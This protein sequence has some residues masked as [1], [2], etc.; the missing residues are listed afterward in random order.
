MIEEKAIKAKEATNSLVT[1]IKS[2]E[3]PYDERIMEPLND[4]LSATADFKGYVED[5]WSSGGSFGPNTLAFLGE[6]IN[7]LEREIQGIIEEKF[8]DLLKL[9]DQIKRVNSEIIFYNSIKTCGDIE[10]LLSFIQRASPFYSSPVGWK[11]GESMGASKPPYPTEEM[12]RASRLFQRGLKKKPQIGVERSEA[13]VP[14]DKRDLSR[15][16]EEI[17]SELIDLD[18]NPDLL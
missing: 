12:M 18:L 1:I 14:S 4:F 16:M 6:K 15:R 5:Q 10:K 17:G 2:Y 9:D 11:P 8:S 7:A 3:G 13:A